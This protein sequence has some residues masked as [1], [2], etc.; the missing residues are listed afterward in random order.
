MRNSHSAMM[1]IKKKEKK[2]SNKKKAQA[3]RAPFESAIN[4]SR[5]RTLEF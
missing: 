2:R 4:I 1:V 3:R 5:D